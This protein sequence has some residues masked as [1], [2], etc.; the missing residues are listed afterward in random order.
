MGDRQ[1]EID[2][3]IMIHLAEVGGRLCA[4]QQAFVRQHHAFRRPRRSRSVDQHRH[5]FR[6][7]GL[8]RL[9]GSAF[10][11]RANTNLQQRP[12]LPVLRAVA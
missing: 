6:R 11:Q 8:H 4:D 9:D 2:L 10:A 7:L 3:V 1:Y 12:Y 5:L